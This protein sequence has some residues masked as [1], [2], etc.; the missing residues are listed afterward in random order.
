MKI[1]LEELISEAT[2]TPKTIAFVLDKGILTCYRLNFSRHL[3]DDLNQHFNLDMDVKLEKYINE[4]TETIKPEKAIQ[5]ILEEKEK[6]N[7][8]EGKKAYNRIMA[9]L[10]DNKIDS[11][12][13][14]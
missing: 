9:V 6:Y 5:M 13:E 12:L 10:R 7:P 4:W 2:F 1:I 11:I 8:E 14:D 3:I